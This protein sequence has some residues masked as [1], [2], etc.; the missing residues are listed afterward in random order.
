MDQS[1]L[2][3][4][5]V[6]LKEC[7][8]HRCKLTVDGL[9]SFQLGWPKNRIYDNSVFRGDFKVVVVVCVCVSF[10]PSDTFCGWHPHAEK[11]KTLF[12]Y[13]ACGPHDDLLRA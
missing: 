6:S 4:T 3:L 2:N 1:Q 5:R 10:S 11:W 7:D 13:G 9:E 8:S 12:F